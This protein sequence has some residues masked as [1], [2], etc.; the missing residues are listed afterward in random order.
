MSINLDSRAVDIPCKGCGHKFHESIGRLKQDPKL[1]CPSCG[2]TTQ[3]DASG[4]REGER[5]VNQ[6]I[7]EIRR[8][9]GNAFKKR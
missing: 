1:V 6:S 5:A 9:L 8:Q 3:V 7:D 2:A 4:F